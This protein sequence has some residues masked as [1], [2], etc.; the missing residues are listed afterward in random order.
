[1]TANTKVWLRSAIYAALAQG[2]CMILL[3]SLRGS[4]A[5]P[6]FV[7]IIAFPAALLLIPVLGNPRTLEIWFIFA[8]LIGNWLIYTPFVRAL[9]VRRKRLI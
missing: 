1:M 9:L 3:L 5:D 6:V 2:A 7:F 8:V 4:T